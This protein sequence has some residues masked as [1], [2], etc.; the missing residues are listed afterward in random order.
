MLKMIFSSIVPRK[1][2]LASFTLVELLTVMAI[3]SILAGLTL[4]AASEVLN[5]ASRSRATSEIQA[6]STAL[7]AYKTD[8]GAYPVGNTTVAAGSIL[9]GPPTPGTY[10]VDPVTANVTA[11]QTSSQ[12]LYQA[13]SGQKFYG[14]TPGTVGKSYMSFKLN[15]VGIPTGPLSYIKD[16]WN[17]SYGYSTGDNQ[18]PQVLYPYN[19]SGFFD[20]WSTAGRTTTSAADMNSWITNWQ[21]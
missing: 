7:D 16:P 17:N 5:K 4:F 14:D 13:L 21:P 10:P 1:D 18:R 6:M 9:T 15:Q 8:N 19:G 20:L 2:R 3:I 12:A 11:Y